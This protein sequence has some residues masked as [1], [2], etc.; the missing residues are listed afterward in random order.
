MKVRVRKAFDAY[1]V[2]QEFDWGDGFARLMIGRGVVEQIVEDRMEAA[3]VETRTEKA[4]IDLK[5]RKRQK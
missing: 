1:K 2:G 4:A 3:T 5:P